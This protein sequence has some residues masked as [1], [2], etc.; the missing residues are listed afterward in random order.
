MNNTALMEYAKASCIEINKNSSFEI[1]LESNSFEIIFEKVTGQTYSN[2][3]KEQEEAKKSRHKTKHKQI[4]QRKLSL[5]K[6][7]IKVIQEVFPEE[8]NKQHMIIKCKPKKRII[9]LNIW[10]REMQDSEFII[11]LPEYVI[12]TKDLNE[13]IYAYY[14]KEPP[15]DFEIKYFFLKGEQSFMLKESEQHTLKLFKEVNLMAENLT[16]KVEEVY[17]RALSSPLCYVPNP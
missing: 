3:L 9:R 8:L 14:N 17:S 5:K 6:S 2:Y 16:A 15:Y 10:V 1:M 4:P 12:L 7:N 13:N 11:R